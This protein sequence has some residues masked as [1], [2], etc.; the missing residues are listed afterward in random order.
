MDQINQFNLLSPGKILSEERIKGNITIEQV[1]QATKIR[2]NYIEAIENDNYSVFESMVYAK[3][4]IK[5]Y[6][7]YL[8]IDQN[9]V[10]ALF[11]RYT[12]EDIKES[13]ITPI[14][15]LPTIIFSQK[16]IIGII[17]SVFLFAVFI[18]VIIQFYNFQ[19]PP[20]LVITYPQ[21]EQVT[22]NNDKITISGYTDV[23]SQISINNEPVIVDERGYFSLD[24]GLSY[25]DNVIIL[26]AYSRD[27]IGKE[28]IKQ[29]YV[30]SEKIAN[31]QS[32]QSVE[33]PTLD[34]FTATVQVFNSDVWLEI[35]INNEV[36]YKGT[37]TKGFNENYDITNEFIIVT[38]R[39][40]DTTL[41]INSELKEIKA[42]NTGVGKLTCTLNN[43]EVSC[44]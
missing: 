19:Q 17:L 8:K 26:K 41:Y 39:I 32:D 13:K 2:T 25:G 23:G 12:H 9:K 28:T 6:A 24:I 14:S 27:N 20:T 34:N 1:S 44:N 36:V 38:G 33:V 43:G 37:A 11:R 29:I 7:N 4:F 35:Y 10:V 15:K 16:L 18:Y 40:K 30:K 3:G 5:L 31:T 21:S 42:T 22:I